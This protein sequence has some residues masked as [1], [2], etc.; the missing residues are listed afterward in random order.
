M[1]YS[2]L[3]IPVFDSIK[4][5]GIQFQGNSNKGAMTGITNNGGSIVIQLH[6]NPLP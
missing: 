6:D 3:G 1:N 5:I 2:I 4:S